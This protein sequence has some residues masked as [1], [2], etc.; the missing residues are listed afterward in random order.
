MND[1]NKIVLDMWMARDNIY[2]REESLFIG[3][4]KPERGCLVWRNFGD[5]MHIP[6]SNFKQVTWKGE[7]VR[8]KVTIEIVKNES[9]EQENSVNPKC[10]Q[11]EERG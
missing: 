7:P 11:R 6:K 10:G 8:I 3:Y 9:H 4:N 2:I 5:N 1:E